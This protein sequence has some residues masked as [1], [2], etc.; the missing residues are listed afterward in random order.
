MGYARV[1]AGA[2]FACLALFAA[3]PARAETDIV[4]IVQPYGLVYLP[5]YVVV[6]RQ[7]IEKQAKAMGLGEVKVT[8]TRVS[9]GPVGSDLLLANEADLGMGGDGPMLTLWDKTRGAQKV[10]G[11]VPLCASPI[12]LLSSDPRI[13]TI[14]DFRAGDRIAISA[15]KVTDQ[16][17]MLQM[18]AAKEFGWD[19]RFELDQYTI[20][21][22]NPDAM[23]AILSGSSDIRNHATILPFTTLE[24][25]SGK[26]HHVMSSAD[27]QGHTPTTAVLFAPERFRA[28]N[29]KVYAAVVA[30]F[31]EAFER[32][33]R[34]PLDAARIYVK[35]EPQPKSAE[36]VRDLIS[37]PKNIIYS[38]VP[39]GVFDHA[40]FMHRVGILKNA[41]T[42]WKDVFWE[43][44]ADKDGS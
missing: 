34:D 15:I 8:L 12:I 40:M 21:M 6:E 1:W 38:P 28:G 20:S 37:D 19:R 23:T 7:L 41:P 35:W 13:K 17:M 27:L 2:L 11:V 32:I 25:E 3:G 4:R 43:N 30:A 31:E 14:G 16:A 26:V 10:R 42:S 9:S 22:S 44:V 29:P 24:M 39:T 5:S 33:K 18:A 36:W